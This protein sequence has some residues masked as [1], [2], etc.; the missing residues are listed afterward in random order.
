MHYATNAASCRPPTCRD[1]ADFD[2]TG[3]VLWPAAKL[4]ADFLAAHPQL[5]DGRRGACELGAGLG[6]AGLTAA[7]VS[8]IRDRLHGHQHQGIT[9]CMASVTMWSSRTGG[10]CASTAC[11]YL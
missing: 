9:A 4:L 2:L 11:P 3:Q 5:L 1:A 8:V 10:R 7:R 6:L